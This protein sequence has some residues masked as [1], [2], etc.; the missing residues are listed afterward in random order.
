MNSILIKAAGNPAHELY[1]YHS[2]RKLSLNSI[3]FTGTEIPVL[4][5]TGQPLN[6]IF[7]ENNMSAESPI[8]E[9]ITSLCYLLEIQP[10]NMTKCSS[11]LPSENT[12]YQ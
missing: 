6:V 11:L 5:L 7:Q 10:V 9:P 4:I 1:S 12:T 2:H 3:L 8:P